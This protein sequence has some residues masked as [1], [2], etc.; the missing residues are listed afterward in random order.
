M[1]RHKNLR[2]FLL[3]LK[4]RHV[5]SRHVPLC[6]K[7]SSS[8]HLMTPKPSFRAAA[9]KGTISCRIQGKSVHSSIRPFQ[10]ANVGLRAD[11]R[12]DGCTHRFPLYSTGQHPLWGHCSAFFKKFCYCNIDRQVKGTA[13]HL[14]PLSDWL[15]Q[16][17]ETRST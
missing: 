6:S 13:D 3:L 8:G 4:P 5:T 11:E 7:I 15:A 14:L 9:L 12:T 17:S 16:N 1:R 10:P 2:H